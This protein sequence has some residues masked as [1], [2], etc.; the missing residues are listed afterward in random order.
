MPN[1]GAG[2]LPHPG[3]LFFPTAARLL[4]HP[5]QLYEAALEGLVLLTVLAVMIYYRHA[6]KTPGLVCGIFV[7]GYGLARI[8]VEFFREPDAQLGYLFGGWLTM[9][10][11][12]SASNGTDRPLGNPAGTPR[13]SLLPREG[14]DMSTPLA[15]KIKAII[16]ANGPISVTDYFSLC[17]ADPEHGYY[18]TREPFG[19]SPVIS[20]RRRRSASCSARCSASS[21]F[22]PGSGMAGRSPST[23]PRSVPAAAQ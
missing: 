8:F 12:L 18:K 23:S 6:L 17:L 4:R 2:C 5:S 19:V 20:S 11:L 21:W 16:L 13:H 1:C 7:A 3:Q 9:G 14:A 10:M 15:D 22:R